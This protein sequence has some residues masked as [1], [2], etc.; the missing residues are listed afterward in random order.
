[1]LRRITVAL[2]ALVVMAAGAPFAQADYTPLSGKYLREHTRCDKAHGDRACGR[3]IVKRGVLTKHAGRD[4]GEV[5]RGA[6]GREKAKSIRTLRRLTTPAVASPV[7]SPSAGSSAPDQSAGGSCSDG[8]RGMFQ[9]DC[10]TW[11]SVGCSGDPAAAS[12][13][14][15]RSCAAKLQAE[16]GNSPWPNCGAGGASLDAIARCESGGDAGATSGG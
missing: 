4:A 2:A 12:A 10:Q 7:V 14:Y 9:F 5:A 8:Y 13:S 16:R 1:M 15:Q 6:T 3:N 11:K